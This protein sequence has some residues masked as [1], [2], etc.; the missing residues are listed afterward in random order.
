MKKIIG[1]IMSGVILLGSLAGCGG[2]SRAPKEEEIIDR[3]VEL[4]ENARWLNVAFYGAGLPTYDKSLPI[5]RDL[6]DAD[7]SAYRNDYSIVDPRCGVGSVEELKAAAEK[8]YSPELL[9]K[10]VYPAVFDGLTATL[11]GTAAI[12]V[13]RYQEENGNL[14][15]LDSAK[16]DARAELVFDFGTM[17]II[18]PSNAERVLLTM[19]AWEVGKPDEK[20][21]YRMVLAK[22]DGV[23]YLDKLT[24]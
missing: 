17:K 5:Y 2:C 6:Y 7:T 4:T 14:Y 9:E 11:G 16:S 15:C 8:V 22:V 10:Q 23:W 24:V 12:A 21:R 18:K 3:V 19:D 20:I 1:M 13:A